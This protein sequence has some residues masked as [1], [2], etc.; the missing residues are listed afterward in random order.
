[1][2]DQTNHLRQKG[3]AAILLA[4]GDSSRMG[5]PKP[6]LEFSPGVTFMDACVKAFLDFGCQRV[7]LVVNGRVF[8]KLTGLENQTSSQVRIVLNK[9]P[10]RGRFYSLQCGLNIVSEQ[11]H[12]FFHNID[13]PFISKEVLEALACANKKAE[14]V[15]PAYGGRRGHPVLISRKPMSD[16][17]TEKNQNWILRDFLLRYKNLSVPVSYPNILINI[18]N[19]EDYNQ[20]FGKC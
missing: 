20:H 14:V 11:S 9:Y 13:N 19:P 1:M 4:A 16:I 3:Y 5:T 15:C 2:Q 8:N 18:N 6:F 17:I 10:E 12:V 7:V